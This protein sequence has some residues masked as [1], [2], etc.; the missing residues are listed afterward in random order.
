MNWQISICH[1]NQTFTESEIM[2]AFKRPE[3]GV[4]QY[5]QLQCSANSLT[6]VKLV[7]VMKEFADADD[8]IE[9]LMVTLLLRQIMIVEIL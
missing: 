3:N 8:T 9:T 5:M 4:K 6:R 1:N 2:C 7:H